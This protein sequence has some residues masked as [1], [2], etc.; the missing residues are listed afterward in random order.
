VGGVLAVPVDQLTG[1]I[2]AIR[3]LQAARHR[4]T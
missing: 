2:A 4:A 1:L 3:A